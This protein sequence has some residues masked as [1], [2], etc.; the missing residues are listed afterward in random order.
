LADVH[1]PRLAS[2]RRDHP[3]A[4]L[5]GEWRNLDRPIVPL[6]EA[7]QKVFRNELFRVDIDCASR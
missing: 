5:M 7:I 3:P 4:H 6:L 1:N 2:D